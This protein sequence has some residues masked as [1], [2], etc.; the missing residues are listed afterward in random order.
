MKTIDCTG[1]TCPLP[2][3]ETKKALEEGHVD[4]L[5]VIVD[6]PTSQENVM[7]FLQSQGFSVSVMEENKKHRIEATRGQSDEEIVKSENKL[8]VFIDGE[9]VGRGSEELG[10]I[11][12][13][14][15]LITLKELNPLPWRIIFINGGVQLAAEESPYLEPLNN[16]LTLGVEILCCGTCLDYYKLKEKLRVGRVSNMFEIASSFLEATNVIKP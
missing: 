14:S 12:M 15:F 5:A 11:L 1:K 13:R 3:L 2:V 8:L 10:R 9:T 6:N 4:T 7:R 16:L